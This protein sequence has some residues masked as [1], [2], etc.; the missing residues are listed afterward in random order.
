MKK[1]ECILEIVEIRS[2]PNNVTIVFKLTTNII[3]KI[4]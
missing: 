4:L 2:V 3:Y 1:T